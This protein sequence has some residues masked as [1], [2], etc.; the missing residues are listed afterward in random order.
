MYKNPKMKYKGN[1][2]KDMHRWIETCKGRK[3][4]LKGYNRFWS[5]PR[6]SNLS[7]MTMSSKKTM[8]LKSNT[9]CFR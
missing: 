5:R 4:L 1:L 6:A 9:V 2:S 3:L 8:N 7:I